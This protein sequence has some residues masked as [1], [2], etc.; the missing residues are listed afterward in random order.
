MR[1]TEYGKLLKIIRLRN[2]QVMREMVEKLSNYKMRMTVS[3]LSA[4]EKGNRNIPKGM[5]NAI[6]KEYNLS[7]KEKRELIDAERLSQSKIDF[8]LSGLN[9][10]KREFLLLLSDKIDNVSDEK[11]QK[12]SA[13]L[14][15]EEV[16][17]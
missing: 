2:N 11:I 6:V 7:D 3:Y 17:K 13:I 1:I 4:I 14:I 15:A 8:K 16:L 9:K 5:T 10:F 12:I